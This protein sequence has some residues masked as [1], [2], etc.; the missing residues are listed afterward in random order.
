MRHKAKNRRKW[1]QNNR[2]KKPKNWKNF[3]RVGYKPKNKGNDEKNF[4]TVDAIDEYGILKNRSKKFIEKEHKRYGYS[5]DDISGNTTQSKQGQPNYPKVWRPEMDSGYI[6]IGYGANQQSPIPGKKKKFD[7]NFKKNQQ[8]KTQNSGSGRPN[9]GSSEGPRTNKF[10]KSKRKPRDFDKN[11]KFEAKP[12]RPTEDQKA[13]GEVRINKVIAREG[14]ASRRSADTLIEKGKV[15]VNGKVV[16]DLGTKINPNVDNVTVDGIPVAGKVTANY[17]LI[18]NKPKDAITTKSDEKDRTTVM[19]FVPE[20]LK[21]KVVPVGRLDRDTTG[22]LLFSNHGE[23]IHRLTHPSHTVPR[24]YFVQLHK[25]VTKKDLN[26]ILSGIRI[27][28]ELY[29]VE[30]VEHNPENKNEVYITLTEGKNREVR[31]IFE[32]LNYNVT[33]LDRISFGGLTYDGLKRGE[34]RNLS[35]KEVNYLKVLVELE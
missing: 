5:V 28:D 26:T 22:V 30:L 3:N 11:K 27:E 25:N 10:G 32:H 7:P 20:E 17:Y 16:K 18:M 33:K 23:L 12:F 34:V 2:N 14:I 13:E 8:G 4:N 35:A 24:V 1:M 31:K 15:K 6:Q 21:S 29:K 19:E 9:P